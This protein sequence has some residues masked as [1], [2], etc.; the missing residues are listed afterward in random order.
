MTSGRLEMAFEAQAASEQLDDQSQN[1]QC[2]RKKEASPVVVKIPIKEVHIHIICEHG[3]DEHSKTIGKRNDGDNQRHQDD[4]LPCGPNAEMTGKDAGNKQ[5]HHG[6]DPAAFRRDHE[7]QACQ[8]KRHP[9]SEDGCAADSEENTCD[10]RRPVLDQV[11]GCCHED[12]RQWHQKQAE[13]QRED[14]AA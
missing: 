8:A 1:R 14:S 6:V 5:G 7:T 2:Q 10:L 12:T 9:A 3:D 11:D 13:Q 4:F